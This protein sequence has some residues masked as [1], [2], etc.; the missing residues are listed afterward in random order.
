MS[1]TFLPGIGWQLTE[2]LELLINEGK[3]IIPKGF[4]TDLASVPCVLRWLPGFD[5]HSFGI[6]AP[7]LHDWAYQRDGW[8]TPHVRLTRKRADELFRTLSLTA[9]VRPWRAQTA[10]LAV[11]WFGGWAW[12][13]MPSRPQ[14]LWMA[15]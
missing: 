6:P 14:A 4:R 12:R 3:V 10:F 15:R 13:R 8:V 1:V 11:R 7:T 9:G 2:N 5:D